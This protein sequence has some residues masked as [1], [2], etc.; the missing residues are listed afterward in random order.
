LSLILWK[1][2]RRAV[3]FCSFSNLMT[4]STLWLSNIRNENFIIWSNFFSS[5]IFL[6]NLAV[7]KGLR[8]SKFDN[9]GSL[10]SSESSWFGMLRIQTQSQ[11]EFFFLIIEVP[12]AKKV[13]HETKFF[14]VKKSLVRGAFTLKCV[15]YWE[16]LLLFFFSFKSLLKKFWFLKWSEVKW[17]EEMKRVFSSNSFDDDQP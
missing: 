1:N 7:N 9:E 3:F 16:K 8:G 17:S 5:N 15:S 6:G 4:R 12:T 14:I 2:N 10:I 11:K 13:W